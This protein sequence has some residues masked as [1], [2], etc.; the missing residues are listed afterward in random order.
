MT[1]S[2]DPAVTDK[3]LAIFHDD[4]FVAACV[5]GRLAEGEARVVVEQARQAAHS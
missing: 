1:V 2:C 5:I 3:V 4:G